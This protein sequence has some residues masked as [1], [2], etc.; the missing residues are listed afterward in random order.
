MLSP[1]RSS[2][3]SPRRAIAFDGEQSPCA[4]R[5]GD[6][7]DRRAGCQRAIAMATKGSSRARLIRSAARSPD[8][9][10]DAP[11]LRSSDQTAALP[12]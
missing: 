7:F 1:R 3:E 10:H 5:P 11:P 8:A 6:R 9:H 2:P 12:L 4:D